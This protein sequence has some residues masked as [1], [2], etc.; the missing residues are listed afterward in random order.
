MMNICSG[1]KQ[2]RVHLSY[3]AF[4]EAIFST[5]AWYCCN[6]VPYV[7]YV[8]SSTLKR[9]LL[10]KAPVLVRPFR[11]RECLDT[12]NHRKVPTKQIF[13]MKLIISNVHSPCSNADHKTS[14]EV[15]VRY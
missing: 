1:N 3:V 7:L 9:E 11:V 15:R 12:K 14:L 2:K 8:I 4:C 6:S 13:S 5:D 10:A